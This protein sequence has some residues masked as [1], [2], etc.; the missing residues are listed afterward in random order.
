[1]WCFCFYFSLCCGDANLPAGAQLVYLPP[2]LPDLNPIEQAFHS[3]KAWLCHHE[4]EAVNVTIRPWLI[5]KAANS[6]SVENVEGWIS[7]CGY[8]WD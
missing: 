7:N 2:Y 4:N 3:I 1:M 8:S 6:I 5:H